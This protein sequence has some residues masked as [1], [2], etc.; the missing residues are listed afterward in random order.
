MA[1]GERVDNAVAYGGPVT[2]EE[3]ARVEGDAVAFGGDVIL[4]PGAVVEGDAV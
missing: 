1:K 4:K 3:G 2:V